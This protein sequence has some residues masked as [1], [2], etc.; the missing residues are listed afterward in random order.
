MKEKNRGFQLLLQLLIILALIGFVYVFYKRQ[1]NI[2]GFVED[3]KVSSLPYYI[4]RSLI[5]MFSAYGLSLVF[6]FTYGYLAATNKRRETVMIPVLDIL[7]SVPILGFFP[8][9]VS[10]FISL[11]P[12]SIFGVELA[13]IFLIFTSQS[14]NIA[15]GVYESIKAIPQDLMEAYDFF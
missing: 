1:I 11:F 6:A 12:G 4:I 9:A 8:I 3:L 7:Q 5:R 13:A 14:W 15:F 2:S 10:F